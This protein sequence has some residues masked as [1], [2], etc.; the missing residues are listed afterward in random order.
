[1][2]FGS[3]FV[4]VYDEPEYEVVSDE[5]YDEGMQ[6]SDEESDDE[7]ALESIAEKSTLNKRG[8]GADPNVADGASGSNFTD[9]IMETD[10]TDPPAPPVTQTLDVI[11]PPPVTKTLDVIPPPPPSVPTRRTTVDILDPSEP[12]R[13]PHFQKKK[14]GHWRNVKSHEVYNSLLPPN[15]SGR[16]ERRAD[17]NVVSINF[18]KLIAPG[19]MFTGDP[20]YCQDCKAILSHVSKITKE[21][22]QQVWACE[23]CNK[24]NEIDIMEEEIPKERDVT[25]MLEPALST[26]TAGPS[27]TDE[28]LVIFCI[29]TSGSMCV[30]TEVPGK[31]NFRGSLALSRIQRTREDQRDQYLPH[32]RRDV[33]F[34]SR[35][36]AAQAA[37]DHQLEEMLKEH[38]NRRVALIAFNNEV[39]VIGDGKDTP[40][41]IAG[42]KL[43]NKEELKDIGKDLKMPVSIKDTRRQLGDQVF[44]LEEGGATALGPTLLIAVTMASQHPG[45]KV[46]ICTDG[47]ANVGMGRLD[48]DDELHEGEFYEEVGLDAA[49][50]G[51]TI[52]VISIKGTDCK[53]VHLGKLADTTGGQVNIVDPLKLTQEFSTI[54]ADRIIATNVVATFL[55]HKQLFV[56]EDDKAESKVVRKIGN[57]TADTEITF[58]YGIRTGQK[59][60]EDSS[61]METDNRKEELKDNL[62]STEGASAPK[63]QGSKF[64]VEVPDELPFQLQIKYT[65]TEGATA[66]RVL[67][68]TKPITRDRK[69]AEGRTNVQ[70]I[71]AHVQKSTASL[72]LEGR[73]TDTR[74]KAMMNQRLLWRHKKS[75]P[76]GSETRSEA[77]EMYNNI[78]TTVSKL[79]NKVNVAQK[80]EM[81]LFGRTRSDSEGS[82]EEN[83]VPSSSLSAPPASLKS[84]GF[85]KAKK[86]K[87]MR[88][89]DMS[90]SFSVELYQQKV[91]KPQFKPS[92]KED[93][94]SEEEI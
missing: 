49:S 58:E 24:V 74:S 84:K 2:D 94:D 91:K 44:S 46:I 21:D 54:L 23:F 71:G 5:E 63:D 31:I 77:G 19:H 93:S 41:T 80:K 6:V 16:R 65:D 8:M 45:S 20:A 73:Y 83:P 32:Q 66:L 76:K 3:S 35:L 56:Q 82:D 11:P 90:D 28:S 60:D 50:K 40:V 75:C 47:M 37:V 88:S 78:F 92:K 27:G 69:Q 12:A 10:K 70:V 33:T 13:F 9:A 17:T 55:L 72:A 38:P 52:S 87:A 29:D 39:T 67:T 22:E 14:K 7:E 15:Q 64:K 68:Q 42:S 57:V 85:F 62:P 86:K 18:S 48:Q 25:F 36:Q 59:K 26:T 79:E 51:V 30:T 43:T 89:R 1:M 61:P 4:Y 81:A 34:V 53:L